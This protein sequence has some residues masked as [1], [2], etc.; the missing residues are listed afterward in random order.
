M[1]LYNKRIAFGITGPAFAIN[2]VIPQIENLK[3]SGAD[4][5]PIMSSF[6]YYQL[7]KKCIKQIE[8]ITSKQILHSIINVEEYIK[9]FPIDIMVIAPCSGNHV[10]KLASGIV[11]TPILIASETM[12]KKGKNIVIGICTPEGLGV[13][14]QNIGKLLNMKRIFFIPFRQDNPITKQ[15]SL[16]YSNAYTKE[17]IIK[18]LKDTQIQP[19]LL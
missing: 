12:L 19:I 7:N 2:K 11:D 17:S 4:I 9:K 5:I 3:N 1:S 6:K 16:S 8:N 18:A 13:E 15:N 14:A 10:A